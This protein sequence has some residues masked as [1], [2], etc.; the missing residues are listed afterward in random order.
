[1]KIELELKKSK[2]T[3]FY[4]EIEIQPQVFDSKINVAYASKNECH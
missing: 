1:M 3:V 2:C 4:D